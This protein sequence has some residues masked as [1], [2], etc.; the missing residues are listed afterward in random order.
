MESS[1]ILVEVTDVNGKVIICDLTEY[2]DISGAAVG[3][4][5]IKRDPLRYAGQLADGPAVM[6]IVGEDGTETI[7]VIPIGAGTTGG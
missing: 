2:S 3:Y 1:N 5:W 4:I 6:T 7:I